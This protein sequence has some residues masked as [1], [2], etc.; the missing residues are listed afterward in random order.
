MRSLAGVRDEGP[1]VFAACPLEPEQDAPW[2]S[3]PLGVSV[4]PRRTLTSFTATS[5]RLPRSTFTGGAGEPGT[6]SSQA[7][8][9][10]PSFCAT[11]HTY[12]VLAPRPNGCRHQRF[13]GRRR[14]SAERGYPEAVCCRA[15]AM[16]G[17]RPKWSQNVALV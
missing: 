16:V 17:Q 8:D 6:A 13:V 2:G 4:F 14:P 9:S 10:L 11:R 7:T 3:P 12:V 15:L 5:S 1:Q